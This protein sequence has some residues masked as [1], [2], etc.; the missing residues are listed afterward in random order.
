MGFLQWL[1]V[2]LYGLCPCYISHVVTN[3]QFWFRM[4]IHDCLSWVPYTD[5]FLCWYFS[6]FLVQYMSFEYDGMFLFTKVHKAWLDWPQTT[7]RM[8]LGQTC[9]AHFCPVYCTMKYNNAIN[10][11][12]AN[13]VLIA[14]W[15]IQYS[16]SKGNVWPQKKLNIFIKV[17]GQFF[18]LNIYI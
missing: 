10:Q 17:W 9:C 11:C 7:C 18:F 12:L 14:E 1:I 16:I 8:K 2:Q 13:Y 5:L 4:A 3:S 15:L 6:F